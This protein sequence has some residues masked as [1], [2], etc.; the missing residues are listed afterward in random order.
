VSIETKI[1]K[2]YQTVIPSQIRKELNIDAN[3]IM[4]WELKENGK[5]EINFRKKMSIYD[6]TGIVKGDPKHPTDAVKLKKKM[7]RGEKP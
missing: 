1:S 2:G 6:V 5:V 4:A 7:S 3:D